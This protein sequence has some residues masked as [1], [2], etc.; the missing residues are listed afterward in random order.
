MS[1]RYYLRDFWCSA[2][3]LLMDVPLLQTIRDPDGRVTFVFDNTNNQAEQAS[4]DFKAEGGRDLVPLKAYRQAYRRLQNEAR[5]AQA[6][7]LSY[8]HRDTR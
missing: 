6:E 7:G 1:D 4:L 2:F 3:V 5:K 8:D